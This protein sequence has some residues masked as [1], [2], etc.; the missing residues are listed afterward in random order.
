MTSLVKNRQGFTLIEIMAVLV[1]MGVMASVAVS[2]INDISGTAD[3]RALETGVAELN[4]REMLYWT[5]AKFATGG[6][7]ADTDIT[8]DPGYSVDLNR[9]G[10][11][12]YTWT[13][14]PNASGGTLEFGSRSFVLTRDASTIIQAARWHL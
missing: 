14:G 4:A 3:V 8:T 2:K 1:I 7:T 10:Q 11:S 5:N 13:A 9:P 6:W 12:D